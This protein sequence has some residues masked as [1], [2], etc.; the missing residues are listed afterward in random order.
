M[1]PARGY[2]SRMQ[3]APPGYEPPVTVYLVEENNAENEV[4]QIGAFFD[5]AEADALVSR[6]ATEGR[7]AQVNLVPVHRRLADHDYDR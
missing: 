7:A 3:G 6:L 4:V 5:E 2:G 1:T